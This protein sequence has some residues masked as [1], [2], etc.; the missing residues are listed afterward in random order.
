MEQARVITLGPTN[1]TSQV[2]SFEQAFGEDYSEL[3]GRG[4]ARRQKRK[5]DRKAKRQERR[6]IGRAHV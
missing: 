6:K 5:L 2:V 1:S 4:R 3:R